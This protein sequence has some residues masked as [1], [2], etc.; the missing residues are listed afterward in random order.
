MTNCFFQLFRC[1]EHL[2]K[3]NISSDAL[4]RVGDT[5]GQLPVSALDCVGD[6][7][8]SIGLLCRKLQKQVSIE[9]LVP[10]HAFESA[11]EVNTFN[12][13][14]HDLIDHLCRSGFRSDSA[15]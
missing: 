11:F 15:A 13:R 1:S 7:R 14:Q 4:Y 6:L 10:D 2:P 12:L 9:S 5:L 3:S 8:G